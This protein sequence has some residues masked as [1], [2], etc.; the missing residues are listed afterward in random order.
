MSGKYTIGPDKD[1]IIVDAHDTILKR[2]LSR[3]PLQI[4]G[5]PRQPERL[6]WGMRDGL[7]NFI[8]YFTQIRK[9][10]I[11]ISSDGNVERLRDVF[12]RF[13]IARRIARIYGREHLHKETYLKQLDRILLDAGVEKERAVFI[14][15]SK[16]DGYSAERYG[17]EFIAVPGTLDD[18]AFSFN[19]FLREA[20]RGPDHGLLVQRITNL[21]RV[22]RNLSTPE[23][24]E[25]ATRNKEGSLVH[26][27]ALAVRA[28]SREARRNLYAVDEPSSQARIYWQGTF[29]RFPAQ[30]FETLYLRLLAFLQDRELYIQDCAMGSSD[31]RQYPLRIIT[32]TAWHS[33]FARN[34]FIQ[35][36]DSKLSDFLPEFTI[37]HVPNFRAIVDFDGTEDETFTI[38]HLARK[39]AVIGGTS[40]AG[41]IRTAAYNLTGYFYAQ[42]DLLPVNCSANSREERL[43]LYFGLPGPLKSRATLADGTVFFGDAHQL[44]SADAIY[45]LEWGCYEPL[46]GKNHNL[47]LPVREATRRFA[48]ILENV[49]LLPGRRVDAGAMGEQAMASFPITHLNQVNRKG[50]SPPPAAVLLLLRDAPGF[51]PTP[52]RLTPAQWIVLLFCGYDAPDPTMVLPVMRPFFDSYPLLF[53]P[54][55]YAMLLYERLLRSATTCWLLC[56]RKNELPIADIEAIQ[57]NALDQ[58]DWQE[59]PV[60]KMQSPATALSERA[61]ALKAD[62]LLELKKYK[63]IFDPALLSAFDG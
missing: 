61:S 1:L 21:R 22:Q 45:N 40:H 28:D 36:P 14:G 57:N 31:A 13:G 35:L 53:H 44:W 56:E 39:L 50:Q 42:E 11:V 32:Q 5:D 52:A 49:P 24:V 12:E 59:D 47:P 25:A 54:A 27:G 63:E 37:I 23:L 2:D 4:F 3:D 60:W 18:P 46:C 41:Q 6:E 43:L 30:A 16:I 48:T 7:L 26:L 15:D 62:C 55:R 10:K 51:F 20:L 19:E 58:T 29:A 38:L 9:A 34:T 17:V 8:E 33:L